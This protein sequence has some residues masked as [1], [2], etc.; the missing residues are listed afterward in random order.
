[1]RKML[2]ERTA[3]KQFKATEISLRLHQMQNKTPQIMLEMSLNNERNEPY[4]HFDG[5]LGDMDI[6]TNG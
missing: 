2:C 1:M 4:G 5:I 6:F 3:G